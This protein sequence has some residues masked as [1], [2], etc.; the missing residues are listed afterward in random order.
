MCGDDRGRLWTYNMADKQKL[1]R[2]G[3]AE[4]LQPT[5]VN[6]PSSAPLLVPVLVLISRSRPVFSLLVPRFWSGPVRS[7]RGRVP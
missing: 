7:G 1:L 4:R 5:E 2:D 6:T 3:A